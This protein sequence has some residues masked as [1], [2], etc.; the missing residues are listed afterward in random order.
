M[1]QLKKGD[2]VKTVI[3]G[4]NTILIG[5]NAV[6]DQDAINKLGKHLYG[7]GYVKETF[8][9]ACLERETA[10]P[11][12]LQVPGGGA[13][14]PHAG[15]EHVKT[16]AI[17]V[18]TL[19]KPVEFQ[20]MAEPEKTILVSIILMLA[21]ADKA[22]VVPVLGN[23]INILKSEAAFKALQSASSPEEVKRIISSHLNAHQG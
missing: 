14:I 17:G 15:T 1:R 12:G 21:V 6:S 16:S 10:F 20:A 7:K 5:L 19:K 3:L 18:A 22:I 8:T 13:A 9:Q 23:V 2:Y 11:T 4:E